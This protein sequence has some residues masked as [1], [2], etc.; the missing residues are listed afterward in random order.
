MLGFVNLQY[1]PERPDVYFVTVAFL[2]E[3]FRCYVIGCST[4]GLL[5]LTIKLNLSGQAKVPCTNKMTDKLRLFLF[6]SWTC[7][8][9]VC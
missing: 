3:H 8:A 1:T 5:S 6:I 4:Q 2:T 7:S 9:Y